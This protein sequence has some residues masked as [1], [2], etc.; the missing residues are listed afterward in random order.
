MAK[1]NTTQI[2]FLSIKSSLQQAST[3]VTKHS[4]VILMVAAI[5][6][7]IYS[8][9]NVRMIIMLQDDTAYRVKQSA[10]R[11]NG[12]FDKETINKINNLKASSDSS[13]I[14]LPQ[15]RRNPFIN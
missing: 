7:L 14:E 11:I 12:N 2:S 9:L 4:T 5:S 1:K 3:L 8:I 13:S 15:G 6:V 10:N